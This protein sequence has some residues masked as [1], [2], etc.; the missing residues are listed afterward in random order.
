MHDLALIHA[1]QLICRH[2]EEFNVVRQELFFSRKKQG[3]PT[4]TNQGDAHQ[5]QQRRP[6]SNQNP[7]QPALIDLFHFSTLRNR[8]RN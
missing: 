8:L 7:N 1:A 6:I 2:A 3:K 4:A 5:N